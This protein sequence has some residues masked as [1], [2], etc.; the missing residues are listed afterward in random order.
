MPVTQGIL[1]MALQA[2]EGHRFTDIYVQVG[3]MAAVVPIS[4]EIF[5]DYLSKDTLAEGARLHFETLSVE[6]ACLDCCRTADLSQWTDERPQTIMARATARGCACGSK[7]LRVTGGVSF[8]MVK[9][10]IEE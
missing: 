1:N 6:M 7:R 3:C 10:E 9:I 8:G 4:V 5:F 2:A